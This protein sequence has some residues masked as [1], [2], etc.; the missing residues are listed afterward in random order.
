MGLFDKIKD[1]LGDKVVKTNLRA[2]MFGPRAVGKTS[3]MASVF[4]DVSKNLAGTKLYFHPISDASNSLHNKRLE[5]LHLIDEATDFTEEPNTGVINATSLPEPFDFEIGMSNRTSM[6][7]LRIQDFPGE[8]LESHPKEVLDYLSSSETIILAIDT[9]Y[10]MEENGRYNNEKNK[11]SLVTDFFRMNADTIKNKLLLLVPLKCERYFHEGRIGEVTA[12]VKVAYAPL[13]EFCRT[14]NIA[15]VSAPILTLGGVEF[16]RMVATGRATSSVSMLARYRFFGNPPKYEP[17][18]CVQ[19]F[20]Y[21]LTYMANYYEWSKAQPKGFM[22]SM[23]QSLA[24]FL[25]DDDVFLY[26]VKKL[27][28]EAKTD[29]F[30]YEI[31]VPNSILNIH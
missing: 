10:L 24:S 3:I 18:F 26:E 25:K 15:C 22:D 13:I 17:M 31:I 16:D 19:L 7:D 14:Q 1:K 29:K 2:T 21:L 8:Y 11:P 5:L 20:Y 23:T 6:I 28:T 12:R 30:G 4:S 9:P 27:S